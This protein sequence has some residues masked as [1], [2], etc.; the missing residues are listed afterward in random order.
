MDVF[1]AAD[2]YRKEGKTLIVLAGKDYGSGNYN[3][4]V[5][6]IIIICSLKLILRYHNNFYFSVFV[7][8]QENTIC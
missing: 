4:H 7:D 8:T 5:S 1:D 2:R 6:L 3:I